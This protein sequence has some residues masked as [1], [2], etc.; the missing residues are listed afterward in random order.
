MLGDDAGE[1]G[2]A[3]ASLLGNSRDGMICLLM[4]GEQSLTGA[5]RSTEGAAVDAKRG[6]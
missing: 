6:L 2:G 3:A 4:Q 5:S 1:E